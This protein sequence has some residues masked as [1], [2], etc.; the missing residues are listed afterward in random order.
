M[1]HSAVPVRSGRRLSRYKDISKAIY[2]KKGN[3]EMRLIPGKTKVK[4]EL[5]RGI[6]LGDVI[7]AVFMLALLAL[8]VISTLPGR[9]YIAVGVI[10]VGVM[11]LIR[12]DSQPN[13]MVV[14]SFLRY[15]AFPKNYWRVFSDKHL[16]TKNKDKRGVEQWNEYFDEKY[17]PEQVLSFEEKVKKIKAERER[18]KEE[19]DILKSEKVSD[20]EKNAV[21]R[22]KE[23]KKKSKKREKTESKDDM[24]KF[25]G[26]EQ[27]IPFTGISEGFVEYSGKYYG[28]IIEVD[29]VEFRFFSQHRRNN[30][31]EECFGRV[32][33]SLRENYAAN[34]IKIDRPIIYNDYLD[35]EYDRLDDLR[36]SYE[37]GLLTEEELQSRVEIQYERINAMREICFES[38]VVQPFYYFALFNIDK[39][40]LQIDTDNAISAMA[41][42]EL[43]VRRL[44]SD[45]ELAIFL[46]YTNCVDFNEWDI[47]KIDPKD[48]VTWAMPESTVFSVRKVS[49]NK[50]VTHQMRVVGYPS[51]VGDAWLAGVM[52]VPGTKVV[53]KFTP[54]DRVKSIRLI[55]RSL[56]ELRVQYNATSV[57]SKRLDIE[58]HIQ[59]LSRL[60]VTL[61]QENEGN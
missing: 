23:E 30:S 1:L 37:K 34:I 14:L 38:K 29:P 20:E 11:L 49:I 40:Q 44:T 13:Y 50:I 16:E 18:K 53:V 46:K 19:E 21:W 9:M 58:S 57:D 27:I 2:I 61:Q 35:K 31:I 8:V 32:I 59:T 28:T 36:A 25:K 17:E 52:S 60:L 39:K 33:R 24:K 4:I 56:Q 6:T 7:V 48:Y 45:K 47:E 51:D 55:D 15:M 41:Q 22:A 42:G 43:K 5:F 12:M 54:M 26:I 10:A 3:R